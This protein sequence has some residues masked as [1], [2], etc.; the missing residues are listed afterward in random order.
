MRFRWRAL[1]PNEPDHELIWLAVTSVTALGA[2]GWLWLKLPWPQCY[3]HALFGIPCLTCGSTR[4]M[5]A[6]AHGSFRA[7]WEFNPLA[8]LTLC[9]IALYD[10]Y[11]LAALLAR[12]KRL[13]VAFQ[14]Q[15]V[16]WLLVTAALLNWFYLL[17]HG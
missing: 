6:L 8:T 15:L 2:L 16:R 10:V 4:A 11:A 13:R 9:G 14:P 7:A 17:R 3:F 1:Q 12:A 5:L